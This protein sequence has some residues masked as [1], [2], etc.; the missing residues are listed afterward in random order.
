MFKKKSSFSYP[1]SLGDVGEVGDGAADDEDLAVRSR[2]A[3]SHDGDDRL[4]VLVRLRLRRISRVFAVVRQL[5][6]SSEVADGVP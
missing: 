1:E 5:G 2:R 3:L 6:C 4:G